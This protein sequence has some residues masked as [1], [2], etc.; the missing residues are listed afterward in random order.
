MPTTK[1]ILLKELDRRIANVEKEVAW[2]KKNAVD[3][4]E[5]FKRYVADTLIIDDLSA[6]HL[7]S[8]IQETTNAYHCWA[9]AEAELNQLKAL[10]E[11]IEKGRVNLDA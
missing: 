6:G 8:R 10:K 5:S 11:D 7:D 2:R 4:F 9:L 3:Y 1:E